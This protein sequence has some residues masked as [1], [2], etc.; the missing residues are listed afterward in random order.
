[1]GQENDRYKEKEQGGRKG[2][3]NKEEWD[4]VGRVK[5][6]AGWEKRRQKYRMS[7]VGKWKERMRKNRRSRSRGK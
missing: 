4:L 6:T 3:M 5:G 2:G 1:M 7:K